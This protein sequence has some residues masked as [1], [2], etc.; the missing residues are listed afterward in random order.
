MSRLKTLEQRVVYHF[1]Y[2]DLNQTEIA[3][4][5]GI[6][7]NYASYLLRGALAKLKKNFEAQQAAAAQQAAVVTG[8]VPVAARG[9]RLEAPPLPG[10]VDPT[11]RMATEGYFLERL[12]QEVE[13]ARRYPQQFSVLLVEPD[14]GAGGDDTR[15]ALARFLRTNVRNIDLV[16]F[17]RGQ[18]FGLLLPHTG[19]EAT[20]LAERIVRN[21]AGR[22]PAGESG[23]TVSIGVSVFPTNGRTTEG[24]LSAAEEALGEA[25][26]EGGNRF[27]RLQPP[28]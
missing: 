17:L 18:Q 22:L 9:A 21:V 20:V 8:P 3:R 15:T 5:L 16:A 1:F 23:S 10:A 4:K 28:A 2:L 7:V 6:S 12:S 13:R 19:R 11:T 24:L 27:S 14:A 25:R 26:R